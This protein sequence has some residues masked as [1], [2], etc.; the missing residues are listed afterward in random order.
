MLAWLD[1]TSMLCARVVRGAASSAKL[2][3]PAVARRCRPSPSKGLSRP[4]RALP[5]FIRLSSSASGLRTLSTSSAPR[6][7]ARSVIT[8][9]AAS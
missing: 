7:P 1:S 5:A 3:S 9:P 6:A 2:V 8:A 4:T